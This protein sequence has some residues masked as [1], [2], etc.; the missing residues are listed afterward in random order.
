MIRMENQHVL[1]IIDQALASHGKI[2]DDVDIGSF[3][4]SRIEP[5]LSQG[6]G[7]DGFC[8]VIFHNKDLFLVSYN[9]DGL[10][11]QDTFSGKLWPLMFT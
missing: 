3:C 11:D 5:G 4:A 2:A 10:A 9:C 1:D 6:D 7:F 8:A